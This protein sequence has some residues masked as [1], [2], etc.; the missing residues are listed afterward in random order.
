[1][2]NIKALTIVFKQHLD[3]PIQTK[4]DK[5]K[6]QSSKLYVSIWPFFVRLKL[7]PSYIFLELSQIIIWSRNLYLATENCLIEENLGK[8]LARTQKYIR[9]SKGKKLKLV[10]LFSCVPFQN[11]DYS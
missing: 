6:Q 9:P 10:I 11:G 7:P 3:Y 5:A 8:G 2:G 1:M 4:Q